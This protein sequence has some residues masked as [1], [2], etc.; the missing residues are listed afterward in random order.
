[1]EQVMR[2]PKMRRMRSVRKSADEAKLT[3]ILT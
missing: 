1:M 2:K 3:K